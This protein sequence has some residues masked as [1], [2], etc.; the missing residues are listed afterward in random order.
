MPSKKEVAA[1]RDQAKASYE[2]LLLQHDELMQNREGVLEW[3]G[4]KRSSKQ[5]KAQM[6]VYAGIYNR[7]Y[8]LHHKGVQA[9]E[10][11]ALA[12]LAGTF[13]PDKVLIGTEDPANVPARRSIADPVADFYQRKLDLYKGL[14]NQLPR[15]YFK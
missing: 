2:A 4:I 5:C 6:S 11:M 15:G 7:N 3:E 8:A 13:R 14:Y 10:K 12:Y 1:I 9:F